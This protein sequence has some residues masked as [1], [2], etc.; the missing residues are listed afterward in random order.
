MSDAQETQEFVEAPAAQV[1]AVEES[2]SDEA[3]T[4][5][6]AAEESAA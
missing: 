5:N 3:E 2:S 4:L 6:A 1:E